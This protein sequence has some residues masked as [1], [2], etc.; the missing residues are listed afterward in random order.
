MTRKPDINMIQT[1]EPAGRW[2]SSGH[3]PPE[4]HIIDGQSMPMRFFSVVGANVS[5]VFCELCIIVANKFAKLQKK[6]SK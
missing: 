5:G 6:A 2:C 3:I 1:E 4:T